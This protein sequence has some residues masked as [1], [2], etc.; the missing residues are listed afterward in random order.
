MDKREQ[1]SREAIYEALRI[2]LAEKPYERI[3]VEDLLTVSKVSR[4]TFYAHFSS[5]DDVLDSVIDA[6][7]EHVFAPTQHKEHNH[8]FSDAPLFDYAHLITHVFYHFY[9]EQD[10]IKAI[11]SSSGSNR[12]NE[13]LKE[14]ASDLM[15]ACIRSRTFYKEN[16]PEDLQTYQLT[17]AFSSLIRYWMLDGCRI[18]PEDLSQYFVRLYS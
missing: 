11:V 7:F 6:I 15:S 10:L 8:D 13:K 3:T 2:K 5:K 17:E 1:K 12:F 16:I 18:R 14:R 4:S 9:D